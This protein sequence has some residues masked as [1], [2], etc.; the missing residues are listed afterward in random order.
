MFAW[1]S[2][3]PD[4]ARRCRT[5]PRRSREIFAFKYLESDAKIIASVILYVSRELAS[6]EM[7]ICIYLINTGFQ[8]KIFI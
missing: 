5:H 4:R 8:Y 6:Y 7:L 1:K 2:V 3:L